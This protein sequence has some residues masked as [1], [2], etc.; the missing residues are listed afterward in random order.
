MIKWIV[1]IWDAMK[2]AEIPPEVPANVIGFTGE[3]M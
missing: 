1:K 3:Y 2:R